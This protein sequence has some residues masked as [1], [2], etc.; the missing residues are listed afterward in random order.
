MIPNTTIEEIMID[1][2][3]VAYKITPSEGYLLHNSVNDYTEPDEQTGEE[4]LHLG[5]S[6]APS[7]VPADYDF[8]NTVEIDGHTAYGNKQICAIPKD[9]VDAG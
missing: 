6:P 3:V 1:K 5:F 9:D 8:D 4:V 7:T 2:G